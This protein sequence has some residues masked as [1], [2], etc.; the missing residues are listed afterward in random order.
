M[1]WCIHGDT[2]HELPDE[3]LAYCAERG[4]TL[5]WHGPPITPEDLTPATPLPVEPEK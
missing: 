2:E 3:G 1:M 5:L 4:V